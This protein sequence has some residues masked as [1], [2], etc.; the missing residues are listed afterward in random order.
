[1]QIKTQFAPLTKTWGYGNSRS[2]ITVHETANTSRGADAQAH[3]NLQSRGNSRNASWH[4]QVDDREA[5]Q[6]FAHS[7]RC[8]HA[9]TTANKTSVGVEICE[10]VDGDFHAAVVNAAKLVAK[11]MREEGVPPTRIKRHKDWTGKNCPSDIIAGT[12]AGI[13]WPEFLAMVQGFYNGESP[14]V[15]GKPESSPTPEGKVEEDGYFGTQSITAGQRAL[16][17]PVDGIVSTQPRKW[18]A[19]NPGLT[20]GWEW[21]KRSKSSPFIKALQKWAGMPWHKRDGRIGPVTIGYVQ[22]KLASMGYYSGRID[23]RLDAPSATVRGLQKALNDG[24][25]K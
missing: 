21:V 12:K 5:I 11:I 1:M 3:A 13:D 23:G 7:V 19:L 18:R 14:A 9:G 24:K 4:W 20:S 17:T 15:P 25:V 22:R 16:G 10:N 8:W 2:S 6:S